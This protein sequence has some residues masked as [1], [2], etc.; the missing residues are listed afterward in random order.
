MEW[1][2]NS[3]DEL[4]VIMSQRVRNRHIWSYTRQRRGASIPTK[5]R[6]RTY[7]LRKGAEGGTTPR[8]AVVVAESTERCQIFIN[9]R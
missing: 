4:D 9:Y 3:W 8:R 5:P 2:N 6:M 1:E 7:V